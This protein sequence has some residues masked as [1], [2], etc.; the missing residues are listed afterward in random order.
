MRSVKTFPL[1]SFEVAFA[2]DNTRELGDPF[3]SEGTERAI[4]PS[5]RPLRLKIAE[6]L[7]FPAGTP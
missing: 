7:P 2:A 1:H 5:P 4:P 3:K 6:L